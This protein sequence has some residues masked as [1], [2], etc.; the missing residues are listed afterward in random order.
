MTERVVKENHMRRP[1][2]RIAVVSC[3]ALFLALTGCVDEE[4]AL[5]ISSAVPYGSDCL[6][7]PGGE[8]ELSQG[9][10]DAFCGNNYYVAFEVWSYMISRADKDRPRAETNIVTF[11]RAEVRLTAADGQKI[12]SPFSVSATGTVSP[13]VANSPGKA[14]VFIN[15][16]P[17][18]VA[19]SLP[20]AVIVAKVKLFGKTNG[21]VDV[22]T[23]TYQYPIRICLG[24]YTQPVPKCNW[25]DP[26]KNALSDAKGCQDGRGYDDMYCWC[27]SNSGSQCAPCTLP[28][29]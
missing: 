19:G 15:V 21:D 17:S 8:V 29:H 27:N 12:A 28:T 7:K 16:I 24:C 22:E 6:A 18:E 1:F 9:N 23:G 4:P 11:E 5:V 2:I 13:G 20:E 26:Y 10:Y 3:T 14:I 25:T